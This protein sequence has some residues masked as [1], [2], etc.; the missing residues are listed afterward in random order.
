M[1]ECK[2]CQQAIGPHDDVLFPLEGG[3]THVICPSTSD[4]PIVCP[5]CSTT[6]GDGDARETVG[7]VYVHA[8]CRAAIARANGER[9]TVSLRCGLCQIPI[10][11]GEH[12]VYDGRA[13]VHGDCHERAGV[14]GAVSDFLNAHSGEAFCHSCL[15]SLV[16]VRFEAMRKV[17]WSLRTTPGFRVRPLLCS[18]CRAAR[19]TIGVERAISTDRSA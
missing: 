1:P 18:R 14:G 19:I 10:V 7:A 9:A 15:A 16:G 13:L 6:I 11:G 8:D 3:A 17:V 4:S 12:V 2:R 5:V